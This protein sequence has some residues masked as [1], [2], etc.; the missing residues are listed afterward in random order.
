M[1]F[2]DAA[3]RP[4]PDR[5]LGFLHGSIQNV[6][7]APSVKNQNI[8]TGGG[9]RTAALYNS[10]RKCA[11][12]GIPP[13]IPSGLENKATG[14]MEITPLVRTYCK[15]SLIPGWAFL[16]EIKHFWLAWTPSDCKRF[17]LTMT[18]R[19]SSRLAFFRSSRF[20]HSARMKT[21]DNRFLVRYFD[22]NLSRKK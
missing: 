20:P 4:P 19:E 17:K 15:S 7:K 5:I 1:N 6:P 18:N 2:A 12:W 8:L 9:R 16:K 3:R 21:R 22:C 13:R 14:C 10:P 11:T